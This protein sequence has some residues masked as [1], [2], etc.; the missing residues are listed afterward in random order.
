[1]PHSFVSS[2]NCCPINLRLS[3]GFFIIQSGLNLGV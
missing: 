2:S 1:L 3:W